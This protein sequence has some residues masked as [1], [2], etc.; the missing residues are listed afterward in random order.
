MKGRRLCGECEQRVR[1]R[2]CELIGKGW[3]IK[4]EWVPGHVGIRENEE[5]DGLAK[6]GVFMEEDVGIG[7]LLT[8]GRWEQRRKEEE[9]RVWKEFWRK[10]RKGKK[11]FGRGKGKE[12]GGGGER[13]E[14]VFLFWM[15]VG[16]G[17]IRGKRYGKEE[18]R[19][20]CGLWEE[21]DHVLLECEKW[22][23]QREVIYD[24]WEE[25]GGEDRD[26]VDID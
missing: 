13:W 8:W 26:R 25:E 21:R 16:H 22:K 18:K 5:V 17:K 11:Y 19:C 6:E 2:G 24:R 15:R 7:S 4:W 12:K 1:E 10:G 14:S 23:V 3:I 20:E 9:G